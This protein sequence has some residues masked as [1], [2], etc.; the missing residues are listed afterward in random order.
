MGIV[1]TLDKKLLRKFEGSLGSLKYYLVGIGVRVPC[2][3]SLGTQVLLL[4]T[5]T[6]RVFGKPFF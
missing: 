3:F 4:F 5:F 2:F 6:N 1:K